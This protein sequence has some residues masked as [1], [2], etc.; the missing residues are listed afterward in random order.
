MA[1]RYAGAGIG[2]FACRGERR[3]GLKEGGF[4]RHRKVEDW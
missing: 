1:V 3:V 2:Q 4:G